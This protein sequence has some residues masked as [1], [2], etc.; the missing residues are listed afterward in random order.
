MAVNNSIDSGAA[1][2]LGGAFTMSG[3]FTFTGT[4]TGNTTVTFPTSG[5][6]ATTSQLISTPISLANGGTAASLTA[7]DGGIVYSGA[8][9]F[10]VLAGTATAGQILRSGSSTTPAWSTATYPA[11]AG[12][13]GNLLTSDGTNW[14]SSTPTIVAS[15]TYTP[16][17]TNTANISAS[18][19]AVCQYMRVG[20][21]VTVSGA[22]QI[23]PTTTLTECQLNISLPIASDFASFNQCGGAMGCNVVGN[24]LEIIAD[25]T[26]NNAVAIGVVTD[27]S[28]R[29]YGFT[30]TYLIV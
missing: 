8:S 2:V 22:V 30:F 3:A 4:I 20:S 19:T 24:Y 1:I 23:D 15:S 5:T 25:S 29:I 10:A 13:S 7:S 18:T 12:T 11:T 21:V 16:T 27:V 9:A 17:L 14:A 28:N 26:A 6:L